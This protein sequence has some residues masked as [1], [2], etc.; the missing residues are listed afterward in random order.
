MEA[1]VHSVTFLV[2]DDD[3]DDQIL[4]KEALE[5]GCDCYDLK[6]V[7]DGQE[8]MDYLNRRGE[9]ADEARSPYPN[10]IILDLNMPRK[11]GLSAMHEIKADSDFKIIP[12]IIFTTSSKEETV[13]RA[14][15]EGA[16]TFISKP[17]TFDGFLEI[18][19]SLSQYWCNVA[20]LPSVRGRRERKSAGA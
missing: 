20:T 2:A 4:I 10:L 8:L 15:G 12:I 3:E 11:D 14:Y 16:S 19:M 17:V 13:V 18:M 5:V 7:R 1:C 9:Y 6:F